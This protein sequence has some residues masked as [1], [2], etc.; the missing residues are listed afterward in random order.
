MLALFPRRDVTGQS[1]VFRDG[2]EVLQANKE[3]KDPEL[4]AACKRPITPSALPG[5]QTA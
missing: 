5:A 1:A 4:T 3:R 2:Q